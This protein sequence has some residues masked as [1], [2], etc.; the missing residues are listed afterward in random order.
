LIVTV[1]VGIPVIYLGGI[2]SMSIYIKQDFLA[3]LAA[4]TLP[5]IIGDILK[6]IL[7]A[8]IGV[9]INKRI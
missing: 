5:F 8:Y 4:S 3:L 9:E 7:S 6:C 1:L 2:L